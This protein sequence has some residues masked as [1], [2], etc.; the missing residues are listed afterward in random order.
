MFKRKTRWVNNG[1][2]KQEMM[3]KTR[4]KTRENERQRERER[5]REGRARVKE[6]RRKKKGEKKNTVP[7]L[8][9]ARNARALMNWIKW[10]WWRQIRSRLPSFVYTHRMSM[11]CEQYYQQIERRIDDCR[12]LFFIFSSLSLT[13]ALFSE[14]K[15]ID[16][17]TDPTHEEIRLEFQNKY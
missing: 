2:K 1:V 4:S 13:L 17:L 16:R 8:T 9:S 3:K 5:K 10:W 7:T 11:K 15:D 14:E 6:R 12:K